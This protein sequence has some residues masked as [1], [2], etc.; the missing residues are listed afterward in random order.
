MPLS[1]DPGLSG[2]VAGLAGTGTGRERA[3]ALS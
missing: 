2:T 1:H 3:L